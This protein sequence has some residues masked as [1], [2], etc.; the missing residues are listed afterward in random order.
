M[1]CREVEREALLRG[2]LKER[3]ESDA[4]EVVVAGIGFG[5]F[6]RRMRGRDGEDMK[7]S[8]FAGA[9][10]DLGV[11]DDDATL[12]LAGD[13]LGSGEED[14]GIG[15]AIGNIAGSDNGMKVFGDTDGLHDGVDVGAWGGG[16]D[17]GWN[18]GCVELLE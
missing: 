13:A 3:V 10:T 2:E 14:L 1:R 4:A 16:T 12:G 5:Q 15:F 18:I 6:V 7:A 11:F 9:D 17:R 8:S